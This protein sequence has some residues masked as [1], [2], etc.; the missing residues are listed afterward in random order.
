MGYSF[1]LPADLSSQPLHSASNTSK[2]SS[3][4]QEAIAEGSSMPSSSITKTVPQED[5]HEPMAAAL[6]VAIAMLQQSLDFLQNSITDESQ[7][8]YESKFLPGSTIG[9]HLR[10]ARD[11]FNLLA[12][13]IAHGPPFVLSYDVRTRDT[14]MERSLPAAISCF[15]NSIHDL[16]S[17]LS[18]DTREG[19]LDHGRF[20]APLP[21]DAVITLNA[22]TP[23]TQ[24]LQTSLG[25]ELWFVALHAI[26]HFALVRV[27]AGELGLT[28]DET[29]GVAPSTVKYRNQEAS[30]SVKAKI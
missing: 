23:F 1:Q 19:S 11:H 8:V 18:S 4:N 25:R 3:D 13:C 21:S 30:N 16:N 15:Q 28:V 9:K 14:P 12:Q 7:L 10:H 17:L 24:V 27:L 26:H 6:Y 5:D 2:D 29:F 22:V 20:E